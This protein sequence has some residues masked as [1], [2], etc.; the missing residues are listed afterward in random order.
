MSSINI[1][2]VL[3]QQNTGCLCRNMMNFARI[4]KDSMLWQCLLPFLRMYP[5][6][7]V[8]IRD[9]TQEKLIISNIVGKYEQPPS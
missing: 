1:N 8:P 7:Y 5:H 9:F 6:N 2:H 3:K 4:F